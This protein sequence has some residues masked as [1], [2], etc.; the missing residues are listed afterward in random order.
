MSGRPKRQR[1]APQF[2]GELLSH[3]EVELRERQRQK[4]SEEP[5]A[6][7]LAQYDEEAERSEPEEEESPAKR[8]R[9]GGGS[10]RRRAVA[11]TAGRDTIFAA[12]A[13]LHACPEL[14]DLILEPDGLR[15]IT[16]LARDAASLAIAL[17]ARTDDCA[18]V[19]RQLARQT[20][21]GDRVGDNMPAAGA[22][23]V[24]KAAVAA[25]PARF[26]SICQ[27]SAK[28][29]YRLSDSDL[30]RLVHTTRPNPHYR[31][32]AP[33]KLFC[34]LDCMLLAHAKYGS[35]AGVEAARQKAQHAADKAKATATDKVTRRRD[36]MHGLLADLG[37]DP[38]RFRYQHSVREYVDHGRGDPA[39]IAE[40]IKQQEDVARAR[41]Q[42]RKALLQRLEQEGL[43]AEMRS[44]DAMRYL[45]SIGGAAPGA[46]PKKKGKG[47]G[48]GGSSGAGTS[49]AASAAGVA[50]AVAA[51]T[52]A[53]AAG[54]AA[55]APE[56]VDT[57]L[58]AVVQA[59]K[60]EAA[61]RAARAAR[62]ARIMQ[63]LQAEGLGA[64]T[65]SKAVQRFISMGAGTEE[66][67]LED[68]RTAHAKVAAAQA[69]AQ[70]AAANAASK[71]AAAQQ[72][73]RTA[74]AAQAALAALAP[75]RPGGGGAA[76]ARGGAHA[77]Q[78]KCTRC[79]KNTPSPAC[80]AHCCG[81]CCADSSCRRHRRGG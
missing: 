74:A 73:A 57:E 5:P 56:G 33:M 70:A 78:A 35:E 43:A 54:A 66:L 50:P 44:T 75:P 63:L 67:A 36:G 46:A 31:S 2:F 17:C 3:E 9:G 18:E 69:V 79:G 38:A 12:R 1:R 58:E 8:R 14:L 20:N 6:E 27:T 65:Y 11:P 53:A 13:A 22:L 68:A 29:E 25:D 28:K 51:P 52:A 47:G 41:E 72:A 30:A 26:R 59:I 45:N 48:G 77:A 62:S 7:Q 49:G 16:L 4:P 37:L 24:V 19:W 42:R 60:Q 55:E 76:R 71:A 39:A 34:A 40:A 10:G 81:A 80:P 21:A 32:S 61:A 23:E 15:S 64:Y